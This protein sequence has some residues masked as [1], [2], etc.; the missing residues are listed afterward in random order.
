MVTKYR[1]LFIIAFFIAVA[2]LACFHHFS[3]DFI[4][5]YFY[6]PFL[7]IIAATVANTTPAAA[8][9]VYF[10]ILTKLNIAPATAVHFGLL[11]Q[12]YGMGLGT[13]KWF[14]VNK[15]LFIMNV[16][17]TCLAGGII[18]VFLSI[19]VFPIDNAKILTSIFNLIAFLLTQFI[20]FSILFKRQY[21]KLTVELTPLNIA[22][23][24]TFSLIG[25][26][27]T[28]WIGFGIDTI[29]YFILTV[30]FRI[31]PAAS[32]ITSISLMA[33]TSITGSILNIIF[34]SV[35]VSLWYSA[36]PGVTIAGLFL[37]SFLAIKLGAKNVLLLFSLLLT[38]DFFVTF[39]TQHTFHISYLLKVF[40]TYALV[41]YLVYIH[42]KIFKLSY[43]DIDSLGEFE[44][45]GEQ[46]NLN[47][48]L[49]QDDPIAANDGIAVD[50]HFNNKIL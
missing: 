11:I 30:F 3:D 21:P 43:N 2:W 6:M 19:V 16:I 32:I 8:G 12:A 29:F 33:A 35:P 23:L 1:S 49:N 22:I 46:I 17:P 36:I 28:G 7:G 26:L 18:G 31:N 24:F 9:I 14:L 45:S 5:K 50:A 38:L 47:A 20:F 13:F 10:P 41:A 4:N 39:W 48:R 34:Y 27:V 37:A 44:E 25:G 15:R 40:L 42:I